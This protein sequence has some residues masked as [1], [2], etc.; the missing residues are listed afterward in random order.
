[1]AKNI[2]LHILEACVNSVKAGAT[3]ID[4]IVDTDFF[5]SVTVKDNG[6]GASEEALAKAFCEGFGTKGAGMGLFRLKEAALSARLCNNDSGGCT[7]YAKFKDTPLGSMASVIS[8][9]VCTNPNVKFSYTHTFNADAF[10]F[11]SEKLE[12]LFP[13]KSIGSLWE[14]VR[15]YIEKGE[16]KIYGGAFKMKT[17]AELNAL[18]DK[19]KPEVKLRMNNPDA[20]RIV[21]A[22]AT[23]GIEKG[24]NDIVQAFLKALNEKGAENA[25]VEM[26][27]CIGLCKYE[28]VAE[29]FVPGKEKVTYINL[30][31]EKAAEIVEKHIIG[32]KAVAEYS[33]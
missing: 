25:V 32:G 14:Y 7:L 19:A 8:S 22:M 26:S 4:V 23:C 27:G 17:L 15:G 13:K 9:L 10:R 28:P 12:N 31:A 24:A 2:D 30:T 16:E 33:L 21:V 5:T 6:S 29:V 3:Q 11:S 20:V 1:M 18:R